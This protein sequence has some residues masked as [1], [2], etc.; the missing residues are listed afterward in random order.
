VCEVWSEDDVSGARARERERAGRT[1]EARRIRETHTQDGRRSI[2]WTRESARERGFDGS[3]SGRTHTQ[4][5]MVC[6]G[7][8][9]H[10]AEGGDGGD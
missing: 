3:R 5:M 6:V 9:S 10:G 1:E 7:G 2:D 4:G 8:G